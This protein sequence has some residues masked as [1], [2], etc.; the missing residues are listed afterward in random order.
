MLHGMGIGAN[1]KNDQSF[2]TETF[3]KK[4]RKCLLDKSKF[5]SEEITQYEVS[6]AQGGGITNPNTYGI[7][8]FPFPIEHKKKVVDVRTDPR[9]GE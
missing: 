1:S 6:G 5:T 4:R 2:L 7:K 9:I 8:Q 3:E